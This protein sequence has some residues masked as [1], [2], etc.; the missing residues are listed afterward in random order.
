M[1]DREVESDHFDINIVGICYID[2]C[3]TIETRRCGGCS[4]LRI[5]HSILLHSGHARVEEEND[6]AS[7]Y[8]ED[9][10]DD[11]GGP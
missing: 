2:Q 4:K 6:Q 3:L 5:F 9:R 8:D 10:A 1:S 7:C 11:T